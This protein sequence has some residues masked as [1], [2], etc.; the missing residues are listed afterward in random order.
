MCS[1]DEMPQ[2]LLYLV[3][4]KVGSDCGR[5]TAAAPQ[6]DGK[7]MQMSEEEN[8][9]ADAANSADERPG[10]TGVRERHILQWHITHRCNL[11]CAHCYQDDRAAH[12]PT[13]NT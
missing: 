5:C 12:T 9:T 7:H 10:S 6:A 4:R 13:E 1:I 11:F 2:L 8:K 3:H